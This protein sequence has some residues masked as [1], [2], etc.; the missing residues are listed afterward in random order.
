MTNSSDPNAAGVPID[1]DQFLKNQ[2]APPPLPDKRDG[3]V[4]AY[5]GKPMSA[6][7]FL[8]NNR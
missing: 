1:A 7:D 5:D 4:E 8:M 2:T 6:D 3:K